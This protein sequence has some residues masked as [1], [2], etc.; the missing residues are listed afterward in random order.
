MSDIC[1]EFRFA[2][3]LPNSDDGDYHLVKFLNHYPDG[4]QEHSIELIKDYKRPFYVTKKFY[5]NHKQRKEAEHLSRLDKF[6]STESGLANSI[7]KALGKPK[8]KKAKLYEVRRDRDS[9]YVYGADI[10]STTLLSMEYKKKCDKIT[11]FIPGFLD[12]ENDVDTKEIS[13]NTFVY[14]EDGIDKVY[15]FVNNNLIPNLP[16]LEERIINKLLKSL[17]D[18][19][20]YGLDVDN[21]KISIT[22]CKDEKEL[23][24]KSF[25]RIHR[26]DIDILSGWNFEFDI[27][28]IAKRSVVNGLRPEDVFCHPD[29]P[30]ELRFFEV[31]VGRSEKVTQA[32]KVTPVPPE[33]RWHVMKSAAKFIMMDSMSLY[34]YIRSQDKKIQGGYGLDNVLA[35]S[36]K[37]GKLK[38]VDIEGVTKYEWHKTMSNK[39]PIDYSAYNIWDS[40]GLNCKNKKDHDLDY[41]LPLLSGHTTF[42]NFNSN[43]T[44]IY[45]DMYEFYMKEDKVLA[46]FKSKDEQESKSLGRE[47]WTVTL[48]LWRIDE[49]YSVPILDDEYY[50]N[51]TELQDKAAQMVASHYNTPRPLTKTRAYI[52][53]MDLDVTSAYPTV[54]YVLN[55][56]ND[57]CVRDLFDVVGV[58]KETF[59]HANIDLIT[60]VIS[61]LD[62]GHIM[63][64]LPTLIEVDSMIDDYL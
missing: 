7:F 24:Q 32:G 63:H 33:E 36:L 42:Y 29:I 55:I 9:I 57:T 27:S 35:K 10:P 12:I 52:L 8:Y 1:K 49:N 64:E 39:H 5:R 56:S 50:L 6:M 21:L 28:T 59:K 16:G 58:E 15:T 17:P 13:L 14:T 34:R 4:R 25:S 26:S 53:A 41:S 40:L 54:T 45:E 37:I 2:V 19:L 47:Y 18:K 48:N 44:K 61:H 3:H 46:M 20:P 60:G 11:P 22:K 38:T 23:I 43:P 30:K 51:T 31:I 62:Y